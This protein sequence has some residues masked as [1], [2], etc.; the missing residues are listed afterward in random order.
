VLAALL[1]AAAVCVNAWPAA[2]QVGDMM[3]TVGAT[4]AN[5]GQQWGYVMWQASSPGV[6]KN[7]SF[8]VYTKAGN[9]DSPNPYVR[10]GVVFQQLHPTAIEPL[11]NR[12]QNLGDDLVKL[13]DRVTAVFDE[14]MPSSTLSLAEKLSIVFQATLSSPEHFD[15]LMNLARLHPA[16]NLCLGTAWTGEVPAGVTTFEVREFDL[17]TQQDRAVTGR[18]TLDT[19]NIVVLPAP[20]A[21]FVLA[22]DNPKGDL[23]VKLRW[24]TPDDLRRLSLLSYGFNLYR[25]DKVFAESAGYDLTPPVPAV[26]VGLAGGNPAVKRVND[27]PVLPGED[28]SALQAADVNDKETFFIA[29]DN[30]RFYG[31]SKFSDGQQFYYFA[32]ARD[33]LGRD[34]LVSNGALGTLCDKVPPLIPGE[35]EALNDYVYSGGAAQQRFKIVWKQNPSAGPQGTT[36]YY[37]YRW[38]QTTDIPIGA[39]NPTLNRVGIVNHVN[40][41]SYAEFVDTGIT[42]PPQPGQTLQPGQAF[43]Y[44]VRAS[45]LTACGSNIS[46]NSG[47]V[48]AVLRDWTA[49][50]AP[51]GR[52]QTRCTQP[53]VTLDDQDTY[54]FPTLNTDLAEF[55]LQ[56]TR[57]DLRIKWIEFYLFDESLPI[58][59]RYFGEN[60]AVVFC[61]FLWPRAGFTDGITI[62]AR[63]GMDNGEVSELLDSPLFLPPV[64]S[65]RRA[66]Y[67]ARVFPPGQGGGGCSS[68]DPTPDNPGD[69]IKPILVDLIFDA[70]VAKEYRIYRSVDGGP[71]TLLKQGNI[72][73][74][75]PNP[76]QAPDED[77]PANAGEVCYYGQVLDANGNAS[78]LSVLSCVKT[79]GHTPPP[80]PT[81]L[82]IEA[83]GDATN[84]LMKIAW[85]C[86]PQGV[87]HF[88]VWIS[89]PG[90]ANQVSDQLSPNQALALI[91]K[92]IPGSTNKLTFKFY[93]TPTI[94]P[95]FGN[96]AEFL[97]EAKVDAGKSNIVH[98]TAV[99]K[100]DVE[101]KDSNWEGFAWH[102]VDKQSPIVPWPARGLPPVNSPFDPRIYAYRIPTQCTN[103][104]GVR[105]GDAIVRSF[106]ENNAPI[107]DCTPGGAYYLNTTNNPVTYLYKKP[108]DQTT[109]LPVVLY[110]MQVPNNRFPT[111]SWDVVQV[112]PMMEK[113]AYSVFPGVGSFSPAAI[114]ADPFI[115]VVPD[116]LR[117]FVNLPIPD[118]R[119]GIYLVDST[120][121]LAKAAYQYFLVRFGV[122]GEIE[123]IIPT[124]II[125]LEV[126]P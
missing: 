66:Y 23:N 88:N 8:A 117:S 34:G 114:I 35:I 97:I 24:A 57:Y 46:E 78:A 109:I 3:Y 107:N 20:G 33:I 79:A 44:T 27:L 17:T 49:P 37:I 119:N 76:L 6:L 15:N 74:S 2:A 13:E 104:V 105:I 84:R 67:E 12:A 121:L 19:A 91:E 116:K 61:S 30:Q 98:V 113:I 124:N 60:E 82:P 86:P 71:K 89:A 108:S 50:A 47:A 123:Q 58:C 70:G 25:M 11:L 54:P 38:T 103:R 125:D 51:G 31:G 118:G 96:G 92:T 99:G 63:A 85:F 93:T 77:L 16:V 42:L 4:R 7:R 112:S 115:A 68:H 9:A 22:E 65:G 62:L 40:G 110:R 39:G 41:Q 1:V 18:I 29:D 80:V 43:W 59:R 126:T 64:G 10:K 48:Q 81:L 53:Y 56:S 45:E 73:P 32:T 120:P 111:V 106:T 72:T 21:P 14:L 94:G 55:R 87:D 100:N 90:L 102:V 5:G 28:L 83:A 36:R 69:P 26:L 95:S 122:D 75:T 101:G 52:V